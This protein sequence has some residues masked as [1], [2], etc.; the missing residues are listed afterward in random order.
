MDK[1][2]EGRG[3]ESKGG[4]YYKPGE[5]ELAKARKMR[6]EKVL[7]QKVLAKNVFI[8]FLA[9]LNHSKKTDPLPPP[10]P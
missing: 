7:G 8:N 2:N 4:K 3:R 10:F 1:G 9:Q 5:N 6:F